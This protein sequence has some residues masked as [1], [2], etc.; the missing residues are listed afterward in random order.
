MLDFRSKSTGFESLGYRSVGVS[1]LTLALAL[2]VGD[3]TRLRS[4]YTLQKL[5]VRPMQIIY[6]LGL[7]TH[8]TKQNKP[9]AAPSTRAPP[10][11]AQPT[12]AQPTAAPSTRA[13]P[14]GRGAGRGRYLRCTGR[15]SCHSQRGLHGRPRRMAD[16]PAGRRCLEH[17][18]ES[19]G[20]TEPE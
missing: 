20:Q 16:Y 2:E 3:P 1:R 6:M 15:G 18:N 11:R 7:N 17:M 4:P 9:T 5:K 8:K 13:Q 14:R 12:G 19:T 10:T